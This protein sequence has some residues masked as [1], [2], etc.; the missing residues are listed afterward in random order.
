MLLA[1]LMLVGGR[2]GGPLGGPAALVL[3]ALRV[4]GG[5]T[6]R[7]SCEGGFG[8]SDGA[9]AGLKP[10]GGPVGGALALPAPPGG[11]AAMGLPTGGVL[12]IER[13]ADLGGGGVAVFASVVSAP[14][15]L[16]IHRLR[17][18]S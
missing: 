11:G 7:L 14:A 1:L 13:G 15:F 9:G 12:V 5:G 3:L 18:G 10:R 4:I 6:P 17:S 8:S 2:L 16:L